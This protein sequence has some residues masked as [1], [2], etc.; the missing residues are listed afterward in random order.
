MASNRPPLVGP[1][2]KSEAREPPSPGPSRAPCISASDAVD[3]GCSDLLDVG[4]LRGGGYCPTCP[5]G[6]GG[7]EDVTTCCAAAGCAAAGEAGCCAFTGCT[8]GAAVGAVIGVMVI[9][10]TLPETVSFCFLLVVP[11]AMR[12][13]LAFAA[14]AAFWAAV[15]GAGTLRGSSPNTSSVSGALANMDWRVRLRARTTGPIFASSAAH[16]ASATLSAA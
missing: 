13:A 3:R 11:R 10:V 5:G 15:R 8:G 12:V 7:E 1:T 6:D 2:E 4:A 14:E 16:A 9:P